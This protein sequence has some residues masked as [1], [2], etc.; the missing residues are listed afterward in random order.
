MSNNLPL[1]NPKIP[2]PDP[3]LLC[4]RASCEQTESPKIEP[5]TEPVRD[6]QQILITKPFI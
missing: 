5:L 6:F 2:P 3:E 4:L 1:F